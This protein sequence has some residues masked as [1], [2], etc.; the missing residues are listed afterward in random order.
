MGLLLVIMLAG[1]ITVMGQNANVQQGLRSRSFNR[2]PDLTEK[3]KTELNSLAQKHWVKMDTLRAEMSRT[4]DIQK[5][6]DIARD[7]QIERDTHRKDVLSL[8][9]DKQKEA[10]STPGRGM[11]GQAYGQYGIRDRGRGMGPGNG[12][13][14]MQ[15]R[16]RGMGPGNYRNNCPIWQGKGRGTWQ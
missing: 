1:S 9:T 5:R 15:G 11:R 3:Q 14:G 7:I 2:I 13:Y 6:G 8:L 12:R 16:G 10:L 4:T